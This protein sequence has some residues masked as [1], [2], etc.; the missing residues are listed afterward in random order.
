VGI[1]FWDVE[2]GCKVLAERGKGSHCWTR[3]V[4]VPVDAVILESI[5]RLSRMTDGTRIERRLGVD[6][7]RPREETR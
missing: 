3:E 1:T 7:R 4:K 6:E 5:D 2:S